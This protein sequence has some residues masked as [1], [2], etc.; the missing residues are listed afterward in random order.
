MID[1]LLKCELNCKL[2]ITRK[3]PHVSC[4]LCD[5]VYGHDAVPPAGLLHAVA[6]APR[7]HPG[8]HRLAR[9][10]LLGVDNVDI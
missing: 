1:H 8:V 3:A 10:Q 7:P 5:E 4:G 2:F 9:R 6:P